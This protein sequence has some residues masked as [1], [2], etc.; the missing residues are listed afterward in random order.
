LAIQ[1]DDAMTSQICSRSGISVLSTA[2]TLNER[3]LH[4]R[5]IFPNSSFQ[6]SQCLTLPLKVNGL[7]INTNSERI[8]PLTCQK[9]VSKSWQQ[10]AVIFFFFGARDILRHFF[11][12]YGFHS[13]INAHRQQIFCSQGP[14]NTAHCFIRTDIPSF[15]AHRHVYE[16]NSEPSSGRISNFLHSGAG[17]L[18]K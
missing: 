5:T 10:E 16:H 6:L 3:R 4:V 15:I 9:S 12:I 7:Q 11:D 14:L 13:P 8:A 2:V 1:A 18:T 17:K